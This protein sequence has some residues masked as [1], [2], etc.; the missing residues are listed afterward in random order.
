VR[1]DKC[2]ADSSWVA[3]VSVRPSTLQTRIW[4]APDFEE[5]ASIEPKAEQGGQLTLISLNV[6][7]AELRLQG[8]QQS[9]QEYE[10]VEAFLAKDQP[11]SLTIAWLAANTVSLM[12]SV[13][14]SQGVCSGEPGQVVVQSSWRS[15]LRPSY[16]SMNQGNVQG[17]VDC[18]LADLCSADIRKGSL[19]SLLATVESIENRGGGTYVTVSEAQLNFFN[20]SVQAAADEAAAAPQD[21]PA[22]VTGPDTENSAVL[23][24]MDIWT[25]VAWVGTALVVGGLLGFAIVEAFR[26]Q[27]GG[28]PA[29]SRR[30]VTDKDLVT[31]PG[32]SDGD[33][34][35][36]AAPVTPEG[37]VGEGG[38]GQAGSPVL[39]QALLI[40][41]RY[42]DLQMSTTRLASNWPP[43]DQGAHDAQALSD[44]KRALPLLMVALET[45]TKTKIDQI[46][47]EIIRLQ[48]VNDQEISG[49]AT[50]IV[51]QG[52]AI[53]Q[54]ETH[55]IRIGQQQSELRSTI[56]A[57]VARMIEYIDG[58]SRQTSD[59]IV[60]SVF[61]RLEG[62]LSEIEQAARARS[63]PAQSVPPPAAQGPV[64]EDGARG[65]PFA[66]PAPD[67][68]RSGPGG[69]AAVAGA[70][71]IGG[72]R[73][74]RVPELD[75][76]NDPAKAAGPA[77]RV[78]ADTLRAFLAPFFSQLGQAGG[79]AAVVADILDVVRAQPPRD[80]AIEAAMQA[81]T[82]VRE[83]VRAAVQRN[84]G[85]DYALD[86]TPYR[87]LIMDLGLSD[88]LKVTEDFPASLRSAD[89]IPHVG[90]RRSMLVRS[91]ILPGI[92]YEDGRKTLVASLLYVN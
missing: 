21:A 7:C 18:A 92:D 29:S 20:Q 45:A 70:G 46:R 32:Q 88:V 89:L 15:P 73:S 68:P 82:R 78:R 69:G 31:P 41:V 74:D 34:A 72:D 38:A 55:L 58:T 6:V 40:F 65:R 13:E 25:L 42:R 12:Q 17:I 87:S 50:R 23:A 47:A 33:S 2:A 61:D 76:S 62:R 57:A 22:A 83:M 56:D 9:R 3:A 60:Q 52:D 79:E 8:A 77:G 19:P 67:D 48:N 54:I 49:L 91:L 75:V 86:P 1:R 5:L 10:D 59:E 43:Q 51:E 28:R 16:C 37:P 85:L 35:P 64:R 53:T 36:S 4:K 63:L 24:G 71:Q 90:P 39:S 27:R 81:A 66:A 80:A 44:P 84:D 11:G 30:R 26:R 14:T